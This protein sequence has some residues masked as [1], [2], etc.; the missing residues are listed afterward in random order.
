MN[1]LDL[2]SGCGAFSLGLERAGMRTVAFCEIDLHCRALLRKNWPD[3]PCFDDV[4]ELGAGG[5]GRLG[6][7]DLVCAGI[8]C[9]PYSVAGKQL[10]ADDDRAL[11]PPVRGVI[12]LARPSWA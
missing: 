11:W 7:I 6:R 4:R 10:A 5:L 2:C 8:P 9:Q 12:A 3:V 1:V